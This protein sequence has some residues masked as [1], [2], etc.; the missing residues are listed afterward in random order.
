LAGQI[1]QG[2]VVPAG[3][4]EIVVRDVPRLEQVSEVIVN[5]S[6]RRQWCTP[7]PGRQPASDSAARRGGPLSPLPVRRLQRHAMGDVIYRERAPQRVPGGPP[8]A[9]FGR[10]EHDTLTGQGG[11]TRYSLRSSFSEDNVTHGVP[12]QTTY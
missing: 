9:A 11:P 2:P 6:P 7:A 5:R 12:L 10:D 1:E 4:R 8:L 3:D